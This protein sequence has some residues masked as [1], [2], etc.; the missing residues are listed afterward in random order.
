MTKT[1][2]GIRDSLLGCL[3]SC[4]PGKLIKTPPEAARSFV[5]DMRAFF[6]EKGSVRAT[7]SPPGNCT[8]SNSTT[9]AS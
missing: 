5:D 8:R 3:G 1:A 2:D 6:A 7:Q 9:P 4:M